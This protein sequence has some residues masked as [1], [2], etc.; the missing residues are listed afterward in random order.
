V[1][2]PAVIP[3][4]VAYVKVVA[5]KTLVVS[6]GSSEAFPPGLRTVAS[7]EA[8]GNPGGGRTLIERG[9][10]STPSGAFPARKPKARGGGVLEGT[11]T[12]RGYG[13]CATLDPERVLPST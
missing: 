5:V 6:F 1:P 4:L 10:G 13:A 8:R 3:A 7:S 12:G 2:A 9:P 11:G